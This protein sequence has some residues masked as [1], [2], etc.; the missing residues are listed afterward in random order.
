MSVCTC[1]ARKL[2][3][4]LSRLPTVATKSHALLPHPRSAEPE[5]WSTENASSESP[6][7]VKAHVPD[8]AARPSPD[9]AQCRQV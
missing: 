1:G 7:H 4:S 8:P 2:S 9:P 3:D 5:H 6:I